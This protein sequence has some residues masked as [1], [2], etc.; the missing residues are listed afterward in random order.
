M[1]EQ[2]FRSEMR[3]AKTMQELSDD[4]F[5]SDYWASYMRGLRRAYH[6]E[7]FGTADEHKKWMSCINDNDEQHR[8]RGQGYR[9]GL[10]FAEI[11]SSAGR[12]PL[13]AGEKSVS[14]QFRLPESEAGKLGENPNERAREIVRKS[15]S[16]N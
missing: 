15:I 1:T 16:E 9:D 7:S 13:S 11:S 4:P 5:R 3:R 6:G 8:Q 2:K 10:A 12:P 14:I